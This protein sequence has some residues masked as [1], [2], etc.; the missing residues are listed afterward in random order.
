MKESIK[1]TCPKCKKG[2]L[3]SN[4]LNNAN[5]DKPAIC[6]VCGKGFVRYNIFNWPLYPLFD[7]VVIF[8]AWTFLGTKGLILAICSIIFLYIIIHIARLNEKYGILVNSPNN[9]T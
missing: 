7:V 1:R 5:W 4:V 3:D 8:L 6:S 2:E 9:D